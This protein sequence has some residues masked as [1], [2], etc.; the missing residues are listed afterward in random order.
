MKNN[1]LS[2]FL[3]IEIPVLKGKIGLHRLISFIKAMRYNPSYN[4]IFL[5][6]FCYVY[7]TAGGLK[8][9]YVCIIM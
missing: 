7:Q 6:R 2:E 1:Q 4:A 3:D 8:N 5:L 9:Y